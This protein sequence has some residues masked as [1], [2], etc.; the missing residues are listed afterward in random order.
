[1]TEHA[2]IL[3][4]DDVPRWFH[5]LARFGLAILR[6]FLPASWLQRL[7]H[8][9]WFI[10]VGT[11]NTGLSYVVFVVLLNLIALER[12]AALFGAYG[13]GMLVSYQSFSRFVFQ[14]GEQR[15]AFIRFIFAYILLFGTNKLILDG[16]IYVSGF[17]EE[18]AQFLLLPVVAA[19]S[20][21]FNKILVFRGA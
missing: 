11:M 1:M 5:P 20:Y 13:L 17:S 3:P 21:L 4:H 7:E 15:G 6:P 14:K 2:P 19:L 16:M 9:A 8:M 12:T 10:F 18:L